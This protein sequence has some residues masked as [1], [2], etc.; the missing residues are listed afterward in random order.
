MI[1]LSKRLA[2]IVSFVKDNAR[3]IDV[4]CDHAKVA[5]YLVQ[6]NRGI[7]VIAS[8]INEKVYQQTKLKLK[9][10]QLEDK[11]DLKLGS[12]LEVLKKDQVDT[13]IM[14]GLGG[15]KIINLLSQR[16]DILK[17]IDSIIIQA[18]NELLKVRKAIV[19]LGYFIFDEA[20][21]KERSKIYT[22]IYFKRGKKR[23]HQLDFL[24]GPILRKKRSP[25]YVQLLKEVLK[26]DDCIIRH[27]PKRYW[28]KRCHL[29]Y[30]LQLL[31][32]ELKD[33]PLFK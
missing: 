3:V 27:L 22:I 4:G 25:L 10:D 17:M 18:N 19:K 1:K 23:Y 14:A 28:L 30:R 6:S 12:G 13:I 33:I 16:K 20:L 11:I 21:V 15:N 24:F 7:S 32:R 26:K 9:K 5:I 8:D 2:K 29:R 31:K